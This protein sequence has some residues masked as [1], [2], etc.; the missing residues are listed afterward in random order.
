MQ[1]V[2]IYHVISA[3]TFS[4]A[5]S[6]DAAGIPFVRKTAFAGADGAPRKWF[7]LPVS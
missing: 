5:C 2:F 1:N 3:V 6:A 4:L 7:R